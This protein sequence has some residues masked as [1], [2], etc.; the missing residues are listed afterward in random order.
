MIAGEA[1]G[2]G[3][4]HVLERGQH[5]V[6][7]EYGGADPAEHVDP[8][9]WRG[10]GAHRV[11]DAEPPGD[12]GRHHDVRVVGEPVGDGRHRHARLDQ[13]GGDEPAVLAAGQAELDR[14]ARV[15]QRRDRRDKR[16]RDAARARAPA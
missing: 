15:A 12:L 8:L 16:V 10:R 7:D 13:R 3:R 6:G 2:S 9:A 4:A 1:A 5:P 11:L 14:P